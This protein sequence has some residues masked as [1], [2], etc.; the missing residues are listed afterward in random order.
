MVNI[1]IIIGASKGFGKAIT[2]AILSNDSICGSDQQ[3][4]FLLVTTSKE[5]TIAAWNEIYEKLRG[6]HYPDATCSNVDLCVEEA[7]LSQRG[8]CYRVLQVLQAM[9]NHIHKP[10]QQLY[11]FMNTGSVVPVGPLF[12]NDG[13]GHHGVDE[14]HFGYYD[15]IATHCSLNFTSFTILT[16]YVMRICVRLQLHSPL[17]RA[18]F[19]NISSLAALQPMYGLSAYCAIKAARDS[20]VRVLALE[21]GRD[22]PSANFKV[23]SYAPGPMMTDLVRLN[24]LAKNAAN[25]HLK[26]YQGSF[27]DPLVSARKCVS[28]ISSPDYERSWSSGDHLDYFDDLATMRI[29]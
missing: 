23:L 27:V 24:L 18:R 20:F 2:E 7:D 25:N 29:E 16:R 8:D 6:E 15:A 17:L 13:D 21:L 1:V 22:V 4:K 19:V 9:L 12:S 14:T 28:I 3:T 10:V 5:R 11:T 26:E